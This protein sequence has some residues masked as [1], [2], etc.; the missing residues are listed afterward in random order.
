M[1]L[2]LIAAKVLTR[3]VADGQSLTAAL[4]QAL[5]PVESAQDR[6]LVQALCYG[7][8]RHYHRLDFI[9][10]RLLEKPLKDIH[11]RLLILVGLYQLGYMRIKAHA[12]VSE[13]V[14]A[15]GRKPWAKG[16]VN[17]LLRRY[18]REKDA[19]EQA[20]DENP[21]ARWSHPDWIIDKIR[22]DWP[23]QAEACLLANN[24]QPPLVLRV[25]LARISRQAYG[26]LLAARGMAAEALAFCAGA[27]ILDKPVP[28]EL[29]PG[30]ADGLVSVQDAAAQMAA[31][32][33]D[34]QPGQRVLDMCAAPGGK[35]AHILEM[36]PQLK[37]MVAIDIDSDR[38][39]RVQDNLQRLRLQ[40][41]TIVGDASNPRDWWDGQW[42]DRILVDAPCSALGV[43]RRH[44]DIKLLR[45]AEDIDAL[46]AQQRAILHAAWSLLAPGGQLLYATCSVLQEENEQQVL[47]FLAGRPDASELPIAA[48]WG[49]AGAVGRQILAGDAGMD[50]F[51]YAL[52]RKA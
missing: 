21:S 51:Y 2:R 46:K 47:S 18:L 1:N 48:A 50:G 44:P 34:A 45:R 7:V 42:F 29:L 31:G 37:E 26:D 52:L 38:L 17:A 49:V 15:A 6:A 40:A 39:R 13:T 8:C 30:F 22:R 19:C 14:G 23:E 9:L 5:Q 36:Q 28:V 12:A 27:L 4:E 41:K 16:L 3:V 32:L 10:T 43:I 11:I 20:A 33:L 25:N 35:T 24:L